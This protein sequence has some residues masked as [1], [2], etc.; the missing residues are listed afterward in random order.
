[1]HKLDL[2]TVNFIK[3]FLNNYITAMQSTTYVWKTEVQA[4]THDP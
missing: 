3:Q 2:H 4:L 1:M